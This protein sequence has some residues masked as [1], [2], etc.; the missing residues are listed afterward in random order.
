MENLRHAINPGRPWHATWLTSIDGLYIE[1][2]LRWRDV[3]RFLAFNCALCG[4]QPPSLLD[5]L[6]SHHGE[7]FAAAEPLTED[8]MQH[9]TMQ[10]LPG[11]VCAC[12]PYFARKAPLDEHTCPCLLNFGVLNRFLRAAQLANAQSSSHQLALQLERSFS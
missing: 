11:R 5:H 8:M 9:F 7:L 6:R 1:F 12:H 3:C 2:L 10:A 4:T